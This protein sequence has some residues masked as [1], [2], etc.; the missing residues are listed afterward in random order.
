MLLLL[1]GVASVSADSPASTCSLTTVNDEL[2]N[3]CYTVTTAPVDTPFAMDG[4]DT[5]GEWNGVPGKNFIGAFDGAVQ[6][7][8]E[9]DALYLLLTS[10]DTSNNSDADHFLIFFDPLHNHDDTADDIELRINRNGSNHE[11]TVD[12]GTA[13]PWTPLTPP[14]VLNTTNGWTAEIR[15]DASDL[16]MP[17]IPPHMGFAVRAID[18]LNNRTYWPAATE[19]VDPATWANLK[20][21]YPLEYVLLL[22]HSGSMQSDNRWERATT[23]ANY[24]ANTLSIL[25]DVGFGTGGDQYFNDEIGVITFGW[26]GDENISI[27]DLAKPI[28]PLGSFP[29]DDYIGASPVIEEPERDTLT[30]IGDGL[31]YTF[32]VLDAA[33]PRQVERRVLLLSDGM[34]NSPSGENPLEPTHLG[35]D[36]CPATAA[37]PCSPGTPS[38]VRVDSIALGSDFSVDTELL[39]NIALRYGGD[40]NDYHIT[41]DPET[42]KEIF[43]NSTEDIFQTNI[44]RSTI[45]GDDIWGVGVPI[46]DGHRKIVFILSWPSPSEAETFG[47]EVDGNP[48]ACDESDSSASVGYAMCL[49]NDPAGGTWVVDDSEFTYTPTDGWIIADLS[50]RADFTIEQPVPGTG[51]PLLL[52]ADMNHRGTQ[53]S[54]SNGYTMTVTAR[55]DYPTDSVAH[56]AS[57]FDYINEDCVELE[58]PIIPDIPLDI[59]RQ[60]LAQQEPNIG[61]SIV[62]PLMNG[63]ITAPLTATGSARFSRAADPLP[64]YYDRIARLLEACG[65]ELGSDVE[66]LELVDDGTSGDMTA[67]DGIYSLEVVPEVEGSETFRFSA[68]GTTPDG[69]AFT[70]T[71]LASRYIRPEVELGNSTISVLD[72]D[73]GDMNISGHY[74]IPRDGFGRYMGPGRGDQVQFVANGGEWASPVI[75]FNNGVYGRLLRYGLD[76]EPPRVDVVV[77]DESTNPE[78]GD[79]YNPGPKCPEGCFIEG[80]TDGDRDTGTAEDED[81][82][83]AEDEETGTAEDEETG[84]AEDGDTGTAE[85]AESDS[86]DA[87]PSA[88]RESPW[89]SI[90][91]AL[92]VLIIGSLF[93]GFLLRRGVKS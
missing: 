6:F 76:A 9:G 72:Y 91:T 2:D 77:Q 83:I 5:A 48:V 49:I 64:P 40:S 46:V 7:A 23:A 13:V 34:H 54:A 80:S 35:Y 66:E 12:G 45:A 68:R 57:T 59:I 92:G 16:G 69:E 41:T 93:V 82:G 4:E 84:T 70:R 10:E 56:T 8:K 79:G 1:F 73:F 3:T 29:L 11:R 22:D 20:T 90:L 62:W 27:T 38:N 75:D 78:L 55:R 65:L 47:V 21:R 67:N 24:L 31:R 85:D 17:D 25:R 63:R 89:I 53:M 87:A 28:N 81:T 30:P 88:D 33:N 39:Q 86:D 15:I 60:V 71:R 32:N 19:Q 14:A 50:L 43:I 51:K 44:L 18:N 42:L 74:I 26:D 36:P 37:W 52:T 58:E 61:G